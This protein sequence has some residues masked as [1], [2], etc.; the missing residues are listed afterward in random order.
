[1]LEGRRKTRSGESERVLL[2]LACEEK[3]GEE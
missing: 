2:E 1:M 3:G